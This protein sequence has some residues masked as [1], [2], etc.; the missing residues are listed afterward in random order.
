MKAAV[1]LTVDSR[2]RTLGYAQALHIARSQ[3]LDV[4][5][6]DEGEDDGGALA[7]APGV[8]VHRRRLAPLVD[9]KLPA[10][11]K[12]PHVVYGRLFVPDLLAGY[13]RLIYLDADVAV[14]GDL[15]PLLTLDLEDK[16]IAAVQ[17]ADLWGGKSPVAGFS[18]KS[19]WL[20]AI[21][22]RADVYFNSGVL[23]IDVA[24]YRQAAPSASIGAYFDAYGDKVTMWD[25]D[26]LNFVF[27]GKWKELSPIWNFQAIA[28]EAGYAPLLRPVI[29][30]FNE[31]QKPW[32]RGYYF[33]DPVFTAYFERIAAEAGVD[34][35]AFPPFV[36]AGG[37]RRSKYFVRDW[38]HRAGVRWRMPRRRVREALE[39]REN[40]R[41]HVA[42]VAR[43]GRYPL[44][45]EAVE[46]IR[47]APM[48]LVFN[49]N[50]VVSWLGAPPER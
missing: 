27:Q 49:G 32:H 5:L 20:R 21:G 31:I 30:H 23:L 15:D 40:F 6:F 12:W 42:E 33:G 2:F 43:T 46:A 29:H 10:S 39:R 18:G 26:F 35:A 36:R 1:F 3:L 41:A 25:Q 8:F 7:P 11:G 34:F 48:E 22:V 9:G 45:P 24:R 47:D 14:S 44:D 50:E 28:M 4:H 16:A 19:E 17:D 13:D 38:L 37:W